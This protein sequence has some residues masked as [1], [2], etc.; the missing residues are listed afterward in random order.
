M[1]DRMVYHSIQPPHT[2]TVLDGM[3]GIGGNTRYFAQSFGHV[4]AN[5]ASSR[6]VTMLQN[7]M[8]NVYNYSKDKITVTNYDILEILERSV[9]L[10]RVFH[11]L[12]LDPEWGGEQYTQQSNITLSISSIPHDEKTST[13]IHRNVPI[14]QVVQKAFRN[15][16]NHLSMV[17][18]KLPKNIHQ[19]THLTPLQKQFNVQT[20]TISCSS[21]QF[22]IVTKKSS[23]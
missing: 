23:S 1:N 5:E 7:N 9:S 3:A 14:H 10:N 20:A 22:W 17:A 6:R 2:L 4:I 19:K 11:V 13:S 21:I 18:L 8:Y 15:Y 16:E 12:F